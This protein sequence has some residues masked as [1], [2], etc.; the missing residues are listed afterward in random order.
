MILFVLKRDEA[1]GSGD[2]AWAGR[3]KEIKQAIKK[4][5]KGD[6]EKMDNKMDKLDSEMTVMKDMLQKLLER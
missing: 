4:E 2:T 1:D 5:M 3:V 6:F